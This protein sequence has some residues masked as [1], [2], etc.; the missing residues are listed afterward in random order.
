[1]KTKEP[2]GRWPIEI[3]ELMPTGLRDLGESYVDAYVTYIDVLGFKEIVKSTDPKTIN[4]LLDAMKVFTAQPQ[5]RRHP[6]DKEEHLPVVVQFSDSIARIQPVSGDD[7]G[8]DAIDLFY[9]EISSILI[10][11]GNLACNGILVRGGMTFGS[12][13]VHENR[14][15]GPAFNRAYLLESKLAAYPRVVID[16]VLCSSSSDNPIIRLS[17][18][19]RWGKVKEHMLECIERFEDGLWGINYLPNLFDAEK[20]PGVSGEDVL[21]AHRNAIRG[22]L[23]SARNSKDDGVLAKVRWAASYHNKLIDRSYRRISER[24]EENGETLFIDLDGLA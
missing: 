20:E 23:V 7:E 21:I 18:S 5:R 3:K 6:Y 9:G 10:S 15:F 19:D 11:Q 8:V 4:A 22:L 1:M 12:V 24:H 16:E 13:C 2:H 17:G 14:I